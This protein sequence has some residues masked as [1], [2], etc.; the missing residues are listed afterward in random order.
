VFRRL[1]FN[2]LSERDPADMGIV[3]MTSGRDGSWWQSTYLP[4]QPACQ[5]AVST[6]KAYSVTALAFA[7]IRY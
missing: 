4:G 7:S 1:S 3:D 5:D 6:S 2:T